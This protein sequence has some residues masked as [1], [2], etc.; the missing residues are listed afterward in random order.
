MARK[1]SSFKHLY[2]DEPKPDFRYQ[3]MKIDFS[4]GMGVACS[5]KVFAVCKKGGAGPVYVVPY[6]KQGRLPATTP[7]LGVHKGQVSCM[8]FSPFNDT[9]L[10]T[11]GQK[12]CQIMITNCAAFLEDDMKENITVADVCLKGHSKK[13]HLL[14]WHPTAN[15]VIATSAWDK[16][17]CLWDASTGEVS[18]TYKNFEDNTFSLDWNQTGGLMAITDKKKLLQIIDPRKPDECVAKW[19]CQDGTKQSNVFWADSLNLIGCT[20]FNKQAK[21][22]LRLWDCRKTESP[23]YSEVVD[24]QSS[25]IYP[26]FD[27]DTN[28]LFLAGKGDGSVTFH[29]LGSAD[30][31]GKKNDRVIMELGSYK[32]STPQKGGSWVPKRGLDTTKCEIARFMKATPIEVQPIRFI[33]PRKTGAEVFQADIYPDTFSGLPSMSGEEYFAKGDDGAPSECKTPVLMSMD[34]DKREDVQQEAFVKGKTYAELAAE[35]EELKKKIAELE[36]KLAA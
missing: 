31:T 22:M 3:D 29:Q 12:D 35:N 9:L 16:T 32:S 4:T 5:P 19:E 27:W 24:Q 2:A 30:S 26:H 13:V 20:C 23:L 11:G 18:Q 17:V 14:K 8:E 6:T 34:P 25:V 21:R 15:N 7:I 1:G 36:A 10:A 28:V 33:L